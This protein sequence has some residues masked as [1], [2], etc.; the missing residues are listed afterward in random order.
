M[1]NRR[2]SAITL[3]IWSISPSTRASAASPTIPDNGVLKIAY[4]DSIIQEKIIE[5]LNTH[6]DVILGALDEEQKKDFEYNKVRFT[7][8]IVIDILN[9]LEV[10]L[11]ESESTATVNL[12]EEL[13]A[14]ETLLDKVLESVIS[15]D[16]LPVEIAGNTS[17]KIDMLKAI[18]KAQLMREFM[19][20]NNIAPEAFKIASVDETGAPMVNLNEVIKTHSSSLMLAVA[21]LMKRMVPLKNAADKD[22]ENIEAQTMGEPGASD[23]SSS[24]SSSDSDSGSSEEGDEFGLSMGD[25]GNPFDESG[26]EDGAG[27]ENEGTDDTG[28]DATTD[29]EPPAEEDKAV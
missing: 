17:E 27:D 12:K 19:A 22:L 26:E 25:E 24:D 6:A 5:V 3:S 10:T 29:E 28:E 8:T 16:M 20:N 7:Q 9:N 1:I 18:W 13:E 2:H 15:R 14:Y 23:Y 21:D 11:P 4:N